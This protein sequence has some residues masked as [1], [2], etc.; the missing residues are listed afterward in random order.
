M[1]EE[2]RALV[3]SLRRKEGGWVEWGRACRQLQQQRLAPQ[4]VFEETGIEP[5]YQNQLAVAFGVWESLQAAPAEVLSYFVADGSESLYALRVLPQG[6]RLA[7]A[8]LLARLQWDAAAAKELAKATKE[9]SLLGQLPAGFTATPGDALAYQVWKNAQ[10]TADPGQRARAIAK[11]LACATSEAARQRL[12]ELLTAAVIPESRRP[13]PL[14][15]YR[16]T[17][18]D[19]WP[20]WLPVVGTLPLSVLPLPPRHRQTLRPL[21]AGN[22]RAPG[23]PCPAGRYCKNSARGWRCWP[24]PKPWKWLR[25][26]P[27]PTA[28]PI[29]R[30]KFCWC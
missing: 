12:A 21:G 2:T 3:Q 22:S 28:F 16:L 5:T 29:A 13:V 23:W 10:H 17:A 18:E 27:C 14:P 6:D 11:G 1:D 26:R 30:R 9:A 4:T 7:A 24:T 20:C 25:V 19:G 15:F 8:A